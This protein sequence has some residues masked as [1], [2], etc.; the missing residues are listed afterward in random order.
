MLLHIRNHQLGHVLKPLGHDRHVVLGAEAAFQVFVT[1]HSLG[2]FQVGLAHADAQL[3]L[4]DL[5]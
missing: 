3:V 4:V 2:A 5:A 1:G